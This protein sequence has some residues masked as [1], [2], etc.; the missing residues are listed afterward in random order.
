[1]VRGKK[2]FLPE[3]ILYPEPTDLYNITWQLLSCFILVR[4]PLAT[5]DERGGIP[6]HTD[7]PP[8]ICMNQFVLSWNMN[9]ILFTIQAL[10]PS[11]NRIY[12]VG[13]SGIYKHASVGDFEEIAAFS[14]L[15]L[16]KKKC[17]DVPCRLH[18]QFMF[19]KRHHLIKVMLTTY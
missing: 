13:R 11:M 6:F 17:I 16:K 14:L 8:L 5:S 9:P 2:L 3:S 4:G 18:V 7:K 1:M 19:N 10:P 12:R 15:G